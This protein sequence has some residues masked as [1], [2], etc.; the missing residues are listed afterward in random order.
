MSEPTSA[1]NTP[2][3]IQ[4]FR[5]ELQEEIEEEIE[6]HEFKMTQIGIVTLIIF[7]GFIF[8]FIKI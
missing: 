1:K 4:K 8:L 3:I 6:R 7:M 5:E 2:E